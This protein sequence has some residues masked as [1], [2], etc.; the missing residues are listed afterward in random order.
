MC[1]ELVRIANRCWSRVRSCWEPRAGVS[2]LRWKL[3]GCVGREGRLGERGSNDFIRYRLHRKV[4]GPPRPVVFHLGLR[5]CKNL[6]SFFG[7]ARP[8]SNI[9]RGTGFHRIG[10]GFSP[11]RRFDDRAS[12]VNVSRN[13]KSLSPRYTFAGF[14]SAIRTPRREISVL[15][16]QSQG[17]HTGFWGPDRRPR[18]ERNSFRSSFREAPP[19]VRQAN[20]STRRSFIALLPAFVRFRCSI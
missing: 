7:T 13:G 12:T 17:A 6:E 3:R 18:N 19:S 20:S 8:V 15:I 9:S 1:A 11:L 16:D 4:R 10:T 5:L 2:H 14:V